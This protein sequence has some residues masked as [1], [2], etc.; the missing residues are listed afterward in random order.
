MT[1]RRVITDLDRERQSSSAAI[2]PVDS[3]RKSRR[4]P[5]SA[6]VPCTGHVELLDYADE[7]EPARYDI[8]CNA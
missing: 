4:M 7:L 6:K 2:P 5:A 1:E 8:S 3:D